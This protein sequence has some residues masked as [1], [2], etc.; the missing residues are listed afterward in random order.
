MNTKNKIKMKN[1]KEWMDKINL[2]HYGIQSGNSDLLMYKKNPKDERFTYQDISR[3]GKISNIRQGRHIQTL[4]DERI[5]GSSDFT[6]YIV[7]EKETT[8]E[9][10]EKIINKI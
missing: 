2:G 8:Q 10:I 3:E 5:E 9:E 4:V 7:K 6:Y 1:V